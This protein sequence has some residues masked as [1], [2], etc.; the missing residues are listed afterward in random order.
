[1]VNYRNWLLILP[2]FLILALTLACH[3]YQ[4]T[5]IPKRSVTL[6]GEAGINTDND[7]S[8]LNS[9]SVPL[10]SSSLVGG[11]FSY[12]F[13]KN[14]AV[15]LGAL[16]GNH[17]YVNEQD[18]EIGEVDGTPVFLS[19][20]DYRSIRGAKRL[21]GYL[22]VGGVY[23]K[24]HNEQV[25][26]ADGLEV[27]DAFGVTAQAGLLYFL[28]EARRAY[29]TLRLRGNLIRTDVEVRESGSR[30]E[31]EEDLLEFVPSVALGVKF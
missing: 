2:G 14:V 31:T 1:M 18:Q 16:H 29:I 11:S 20:K 30:V 19:V 24:F 8:S 12:F 25:D 7:G 23:G 26:S 9:D 15:E 22:G 28:T 4:K 13:W 21:S 27:N 3:S 5:V 17:D 10:D 6:E